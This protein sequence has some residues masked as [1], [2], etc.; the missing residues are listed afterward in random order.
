[1]SM[2]I[3]TFSIIAGSE[4]C[5]ARCSFC[6]SSMTHQGGVGLK[7]PDVNWRNFDK[8]CRLAELSGVTTAMLTGKGEP[9]LFPEQVARFLEALEPY[10]F[11]LVELQTNGIAIADGLAQMDQRWLE[12]LP[13]WHALGLTTVAISIV[14]EDQEKNRGIYVPYRKDYPDLPRLVERL[15]RLGFSVRLACTM[16][17]GYVDSP[18]SVERLVNFAREHQVEQLTI[19]PVTRPE[20]TRD[21][22]AYDWVD[23]HVVWPSMLQ[24]IER[25]AQKSG[26]R[27]M[28]LAHGATVYDVAGQ[29]L[30]VTDCLTLPRG[31]DE[32]RNLIFYP[33]GHLRYAWQHPGA[34]IL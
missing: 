5:N 17:K 15:H 34:I 22:A 7:E 24:D 18:E 13:R 20:E 23:Q 10:R 21:K 32:M 28:T 30:C 11:P 8:A 31:A 9:T 26:T 19:R 6:V 29:N 14:S 33:D 27:V 3:R 1:M 25:W 12:R 2:K 16:L 4:A